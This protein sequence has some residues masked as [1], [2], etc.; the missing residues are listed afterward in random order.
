MKSILTKYVGPGN[1]RGSRVIATDD[2][3]RNKIT[4]EWDDALDSDG[5]HDAAARALC[6]KMGWVNSPLMRGGMG[7]KGNV[8]VFDQH[9]NRVRFTD[10][11]ISADREKHRQKIVE[12]M[13][14][15]PDAYPESTT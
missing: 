5:N 1:V 13:K 12:R 7:N 4:L 10:A 2:E 8:Y 6:I 9:A 15:H 3:G 11:E 14:S